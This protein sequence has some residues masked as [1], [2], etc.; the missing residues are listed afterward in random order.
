MISLKCKRCGTELRN[1]D[2]FCYH[3]GQKTTVIQR[4]LASRALI[5][6]M[7]AIF[8]VV[9]AAV[10]A[11]FI[12]TGKIQFPDF[13]GSAVAEK[14]A[15]PLHDENDEKPAQPTQEPE[16]QLAATPEPTEPP[17]EIEDVTDEMKPELKTLTKRLRPFLAFSSKYYQNRSRTFKWDDGVATVMALYNLQQ[18]DGTVKY[19]DKYSDIKKKVKREMKKLFADYAKYDLTYGG[20]FP[21]YIYRRTGD[22]VVY[23]ASRITGRTYSMSVDKVIA[24][25]QDKYRVIASACLVSQYNKANKGY[26][27]KYTIYVEKDDSAEYGYVVRKIKLY[28][29]K[30]A[31]IA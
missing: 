25:E 2:E 4:M 26:V 24:Y 19:G 14:T 15:A 17:F 21:D 12:W 9:L 22:T 7:I 3:C 1:D 8:V 10:A 18:A 30:D 16:P 28:K 29:K 27:Q 6:S 23:N 13:R 31:K 5:G 11:Y 20:S